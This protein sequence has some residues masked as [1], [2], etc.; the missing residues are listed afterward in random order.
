MPVARR[1]DLPHLTITSASASVSASVSVLVVVAPLLLLD[2][3]ARGAEAFASD[4]PLSFATRFLGPSSSTLLSSWRQYKKGGWA[5]GYITSSLSLSPPLLT[6]NIFHTIASLTL[7]EKPEFRPLNA[8]VLSAPT[9][10][11]HPSRNG[12]QRSRRIAARFRTRTA[13]RDLYKAATTAANGFFDQVSLV[14]LKRVICRRGEKA[15][16]PASRRRGGEKTVW[17]GAVRCGAVV[18]LSLVHFTAQSHC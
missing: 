12:A 5:G 3:R 11:P 17:C 8:R 16:A 15:R 14:E 4:V 6:S 1:F 9:T 18:N 13:R 7:L 10:S 2:V